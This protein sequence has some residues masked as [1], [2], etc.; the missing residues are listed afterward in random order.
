MTNH[1]SDDLDIYSNE[2][3]E[4]RIKNKHH[5]TFFELAILKINFSARFT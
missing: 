4:E 2:S 5:D 1:I 3:E